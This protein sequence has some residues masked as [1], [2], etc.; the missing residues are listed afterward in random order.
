MSMN[1]MDDMECRKNL[2]WEISALSFALYDMNLFLDTHPHDAEAKAYFQEFKKAYVQKE[3]EYAAR[4]YPLMQVFCED[5]KGW[6]WNA[7]PL[8]WEGGCR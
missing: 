4:F 8:P 2:L 5:G 7:G 3:K 6:N 1:Q